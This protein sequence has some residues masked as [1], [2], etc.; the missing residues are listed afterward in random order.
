MKIKDKLNGYKMPMTIIATILVAGVSWK[1]L[2]LPRPALDIEVIAVAQYS[3]GTRSL[4]M[5]SDRRYLED[6]VYRLKRRL[7]KQPNN[8]D[9]RLRI[10][11]LRGDIEEIKMKI[12]KLN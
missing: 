9:L 7:E 2:G 11:N 6:K 1:T 4:Q 10:R 12:R 5:R 3:K 8:E